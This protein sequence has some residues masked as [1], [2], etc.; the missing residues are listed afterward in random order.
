MVQGPDSSGK[1]PV[2]GMEKFR[3][4]GEKLEYVHSQLS[5]Y[6][7]E[8]DDLDKAWAEWEAT[9]D[10]TKDSIMVIDRDSRIVQANLATSQLLGKPLEEIIG[11]T[12]WKAVHGTPKPP[13]ECPLVKTLSSGK[14]EEMEIHIPGKDIWFEVST[15]PIL[16]P[17]GKTS[18]VVHIM[19][20]VTERKKAS[21]LLSQSE[22]KYRAIFEGA[23]DGIVYADIKA[24]VVD[25]NPAFTEITGI[26]RDQ[27]VGK[28]AF[29]LARRFAKAKDIPRLLKIVSRALTGKPSGFYELEI[30]NKIV[31]ISTPSLRKEK[32]GITGVLRDITEQKRSQKFLRDSEE[33]YRR[34]FENIIDVYYRTDLDGNLLL[35][36]P[37][38][39]KLL[40]YNKVDDLV[41]INIKEFYYCP[42]DRAI[43]LQKLAKHSRIINY[44]VTLRRKDGA[45]VVGE[46][47][48]HFVYDHTG[49]P[50][51][52]EG[53]FRD[54]S[55]R[56]RAE[57]ALRESE[58]RFRGIFENALIGMYQTT[59]DGRILMAN[60]SLARMLGYPSVEALSTRNLEEEGFETDYPRSQFKKKIEAKGSVSGLESAWR[61]H[62]GTTLFVRESA[63]VICDKAGRTL[64][65][66][67]T[68][69]DITDRQRA[70]KALRESEQRLI[71]A[72][73]IAKMGDFTWD[74]ETGATTWSDALYDLLGYN[75][76]EEID[77]AKVNGEIH[78]PDDLSRITQWLQDCIASGGEELTPNEYRLIRKDGKTIYVRTQGIIKHRGGKQPKIFATLQDITE[79]KVTE[80]KLADTTAFQ[81]VL[82]AI[83]GVLENQSEQEVWNVFLES[84]VAEY[85]FKMAWFG[86]NENGQVHP[87]MWAGS[88]DTYLD[89]LILDIAEPTNP[90]ATCAMSQCIFSRQ[91]FGYADLANDPGFRPWR[92]DALQHG[93][94]SNMALPFI[95][96]GRVEGG[97]M[98][99]AS[100]AHGFSGERIGQLR[101][102]VDDM[103]QRLCERR[104]RER[105]RH[106]IQ[107]SETQLKKAQE[108]AH[109]GSWHLDMGTDI[110]TW[111][112]ET[113]RIF[114]VP[115]RRPLRE[116]DFLAM[117]YPDD[118]AYVRRTWADA[119]QGG[120]YDIEH[121]I[122]VGDIVK[123][124][125]E[126]AE[127][128][129][130]AQ[131]KPLFGIGTVQDI[132]ELKEMEQ[133]R[134][135]HLRFLEHMDRISRAI[136][137]GNDLEQMMG[138]V[139]DQVL[140]IFEC[141]RAWLLYPCDPNAATWRVPMERTRP[142]CP[143]AMALGVEIP[144][145]PE[146][147]ERFRMA[148]E[149]RNP[150]KSGSGADHLLLPE[151]ADKFGFQA[152]MIMAIYP[153]IGSP[154]LFGLHQ[155]SY[156]RE[157]APNEERLFQEIGRRLEDALTSLIMLRELKENEERLHAALD[158]GKLGTWDWDMTTER[159]VWDGHHEKIFGF[160]PGEFDG[161]YATFESRI[162]PDD[163]EGFRE[164]IEKSSREHVDYTHEYRVLRP[165]GTI[166]WVAGTGHYHWDEQGHPN[167]LLG[168]ITD[169][170]NRKEA[171]VTIR[172]SE[173]FLNSVIE[174]TPN[175]MW[176][177]DEK[178]TIIRINQALRELL[179]IKEKEIIGKY[180]VL[181]D[182]QLKDQGLLAIVE[183]V[184]TKGQIVNFEL[185]YDTAQERQLELK[186][187]VQKYLELTLSPLL[188]GDG[189]L[190][191]VICQYKDITERKKAE[192]ELREYQEKLKAMASEMLTTQERERQR[193]AVGLHDD[194]CQKLVLSKLTLESSL[195]SIT[196][197]RL[198]ASLKTAAE[199]LGETIR[200][201]ESLTFQ[202]SDP[203]LREFGFVAALEKYLST[204]I[205]AKHGIAFELETD[206]EIETVA[207]LPVVF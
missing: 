155:C 136:Q 199:T 44:E 32:S 104:R 150:I 125:R 134:V 33:K 74:V 88:V 153:K 160:N 64:Y 15:D 53:I 206:E 85:G 78:H 10:A 7:A 100:T 47:N 76:S 57:E 165:D 137:G 187:H 176:L 111:S 89:G 26:P 186:N 127:V 193:L 91:P 72:Q 77:F 16:N 96:D 105:A 135:T 167:R 23:V 205:D 156:A 94:G 175:P 138:N 95:V 201:T 84:L 54:I 109:V 22:E 65:Y 42:E 12:C 75:K 25:A 204:E 180:N 62:D 183:K 18:S 157:W 37:S 159:I 119:L 55:D 50:V 164:A 14:H 207:Q 149:S 1:D 174:N 202:L 123:W 195:R 142:G 66:Q 61:K 116:S 19:R 190:T 82:A 86:S 181:K 43:F 182:R 126:K 29:S 36:S 103:S 9:F 3:K 169:V 151:E 171:E 81:S 198:T 185:R 73:H 13:K 52:I 147:T 139:L 24:R 178:G 192:I 35:F 87:S 140:D 131:G 129:Y 6:K 80:Q 28:S 168:V 148:L 179:R 98:V 5:K 70:E 124:V 173:E 203:V 46:T 196:D 107:E 154:W 40:G 60:S 17:R 93:F 189:R 114:G 194:I 170:T 2:E 83:R 69:E 152:A 146:L 145:H 11:R 102:L 30:N 106:A 39:L 117:V 133:E 58:R 132:T 163:V 143:G 4:H 68:V 101:S 45:P 112:D 110:L 49:Q 59:P 177:S 184:F 197:A 200:Q 31:E 128:E 63:Q 113:Y 161:H 90:D 48:S 120:P 188:D 191:N 118:I 51:A 162:H 27:V 108:V 8:D 121:R 92:Q 79:R 38:G 172:Q 21:E 141:D 99:Y 130:D 122:L 71:E 56:R 166:R 144:M 41:G 97:V 20:D 34:I 115:V 158:A 67:G